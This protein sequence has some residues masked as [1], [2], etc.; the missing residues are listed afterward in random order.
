MEVFA[1][2]QHGIDFARYYSWDEIDH[3]TWKTDLF[4]HV[5]GQDTSGKKISAS[6]VENRSFL[7]I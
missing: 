6:T 1:Q 5:L 2:R 7:T 3:E 4:V